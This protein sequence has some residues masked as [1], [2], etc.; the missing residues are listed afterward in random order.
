MPASSSSAAPSSPPSSPQLEVL[1]SVAADDDEREEDDDVRAAQRSAKRNKPPTATAAAATPKA[2]NAAASS[3]TTTQA[4]VVKWDEKQ[5]AAFV[6]SIAP[7]FGEYR[8]AL[9]KNGLNGA[10]LLLYTS[11]EKPDNIIRLFSSMKLPEI[12]A[13]RVFTE[14]RA[15]AQTH[16]PMSTGGV[17]RVLNMQAVAWQY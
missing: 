15:M 8:E 13:A 5:V 10:T 7:A 16:T 3:I 1:A 9:I 6:A 12:I 14:V 4:D 17:A 11:V 2:L